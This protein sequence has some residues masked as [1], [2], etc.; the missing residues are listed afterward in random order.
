MLAESTGQ[1]AQPDTSVSS[2]SPT[3]ERRPQ[4]RGTGAIVSLKCARRRRRIRCLRRSGRVFVVDA[5]DDPIAASSSRRTSAHPQQCPTRCNRLYP[6]PAA[7]GRHS[8]ASTFLSAGLPGPGRGHRRAGRPS[9][10]AVGAAQQGWD[11]GRG[12]RP[13]LQERLRYQQRASA[14][15]GP[16]DVRCIGCRLVVA[17]GILGCRYM[18]TCQIGLIQAYGRFDH[19]F[20]VPSNSQGNRNKYKRLIMKPDAFVSTACSTRRPRYP[21]DYGLVTT[22]WAKTATPWT[23]VLLEEPTFPGCVINC[24]ASACSA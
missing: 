16:I 3:Q 8:C 7:T 13:A 14:Y 17:G 12:V 10:A 15:S 23:L 2:D 19:G 6:R 4:S 22:P 18:L 24:R 9:V 20:D 5:G 11:A 21:D 1:M